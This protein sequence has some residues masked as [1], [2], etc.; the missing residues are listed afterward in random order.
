[1]AVNLASIVVGGSGYHLFGWVFRLEPA[2]VWRWTP[3]RTLDMPWTWMLFLGAGNTVLAV[4]VAFVYAWLYEGLP[5]QGWQ[6]GLVFG[7]AIWAAG[8]LPAAF[9]VYALVRIAAGAALYFTL[10]GLLE[11]WVYGLLLGAIYRPHP[12][13]A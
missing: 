1:L 6:R 9:T 5:G 11:C 7:T 3:E 12:G 10:Q 13:T 2:D 8:L 4:V